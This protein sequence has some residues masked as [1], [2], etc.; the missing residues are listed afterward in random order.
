[1]R[2]QDSNLRP[3]G[4]EHTGLNGKKRRKPRKN[5]PVFLFLP[6]IR[7]RTA[8]NRPSQSCRQDGLRISFF[9]SAGETPR[10]SNSITGEFRPRNWRHKDH[11]ISRC[12]LK[13]PVS[14][15]I[16]ATPKDRRNTTFL[17]RCSAFFSGMKNILLRKK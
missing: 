17:F 6:T 5:R 10:C 9:P 2:R 12:L 3:P 1:M 4:Y 13:L 14:P 11:H 15:S 16:A 8:R 7:R